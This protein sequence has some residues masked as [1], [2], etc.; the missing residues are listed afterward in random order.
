MSR[1]RAKVAK[2]KSV[3]KDA[4]APQKK[5]ISRSATQTGKNVRKVEDVMKAYYKRDSNGAVKKHRSVMQKSFKWAKDHKKKII[6]AIEI[7]SAVAGGLA[8]AGGIG[9]VGYGAG[10]LAGYAAGQLAAFNAETFTFGGALGAIS[11]PFADAAIA[12]QTN[13]AALAARSMPEFIAAGDEPATNMM[14]SVASRV[15]SMPRLGR[16]IRNIG[17]VRSF[18]EGLTV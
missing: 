5:A 16:G 11:E 18:G 7:T 14:G 6:K 9:Y 2:R 17:N 15:K 1:T 8:L 13:T 4:R 3:P 10:K 12:E